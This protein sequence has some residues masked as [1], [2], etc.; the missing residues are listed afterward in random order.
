MV[1]DHIGIVVKSLDDGIASWKD[2]F[3]YR[4]ATEKIT[5]T[6]QQVHVVFLEKKGSLTVK[7]V[8][9]ASPQSAVAALAKRGGGLHHICFR[10]RN[11]DSAIRDL[12]AKDLRVLAAPQ[13]GEAFDNENIAFIYAKQGLNVELIDTEKKAGRLHE[14]FPRDKSDG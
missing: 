13:P 14:A 1:I 7:L 3:G 6:R 12:K 9:P 4:Q 10:C 8:A 5:N 11:L 2:L